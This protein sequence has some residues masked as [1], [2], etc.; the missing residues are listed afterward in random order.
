MEISTAGAV[1]I[2][3]GFIVLSF[4]LSKRIGNKS[5]DKRPKP[6]PIV[7]SR[8]VASKEDLPDGEKFGTIYQAGNVLYVYSVNGWVLYEIVDDPTGDRP[9]NTDLR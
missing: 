2:V 9:P 5:D 6:H 3:L 7:V 4:I 8:T 1:F